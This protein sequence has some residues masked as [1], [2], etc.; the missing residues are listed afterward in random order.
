MFTSTSTNSK[1]EHVLQVKKRGGVVRTVVK[2]AAVAA[3]G[4]GAAFAVA[5][6]R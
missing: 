4:A 6:V 2:A 3:V 5:R 1:E